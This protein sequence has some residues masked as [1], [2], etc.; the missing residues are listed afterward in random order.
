MA[1]KDKTIQL[2]LLVTLTM[3]VGVLVWADFERKNTHGLECVHNCSSVRWL[4]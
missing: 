3:V 2:V 4:L 1:M